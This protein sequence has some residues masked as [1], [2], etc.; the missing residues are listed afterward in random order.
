MIYR[1]TKENTIAVTILMFKLILNETCRVC[2][3][4]RACVLVQFLVSSSFLYTYRS[5]RP[6]IFFGHDN[7]VVVTND[8]MSGVE[9]YA[10]E[11]Y[12]D[13]NLPFIPLVCFTWV[14]P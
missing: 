9:C 11:R 4:V 12:R 7:T 10:T 2:V 13:V 14:C 1:K 8:P 3:C 6:W 5:Y